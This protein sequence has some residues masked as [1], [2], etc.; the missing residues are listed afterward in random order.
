MIRNESTCKERIIVLGEY[1]H[2]DYKENRRQQIAS[3][4]ESRQYSSLTNG[5]PRDLNMT[6][7]YLTM[8]KAV[9]FRA[10][11]SCFVLEGMNISARF[12]YDRK[13]I[14]DACNRLYLDTSNE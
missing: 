14:E 11:S 6:N 4:N 10:T 9:H 3:D 13:V 1:H 5:I 7:C 8:A 2:V 12:A